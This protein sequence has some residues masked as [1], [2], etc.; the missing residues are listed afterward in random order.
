M[1]NNVWEGKT[2]LAKYNV[3]EFCKEQ[4]MTVIEFAEMLQLRP[5]V[6]YRA[7]EG[8][9]LVNETVKKMNDFIEENTDFPE[10]FLLERVPY[11]PSNRGRK[12]GSKNKN[13]PVKIV[14]IEEYNKEKMEPQIVSR[15]QIK[16]YVSDEEIFTALA[17]GDIVYQDNSAYSYQLLMDNGCS[18]VLKLRDDKPVFL[19]CAIDLS[20]SYYTLRKEKLSIV[21]GKK[22]RSKNGEEVNI[23]SRGDDGLFKGVI[24]G[25]CGIY[26]YNEDGENQDTSA[27]ANLYN[28]DEELA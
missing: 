21:V 18:I 27:G 14:S 23:F 5:T 24:T 17:N 6:I 19:N 7:M 8:K 25:N 10:S 12:N 9:K 13:S 22:Y 2:S 16:S 11:V 15:K 4:N 26:S 20:A 3:R 1:R 28:L